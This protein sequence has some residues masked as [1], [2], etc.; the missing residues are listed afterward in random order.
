MNIFIAIFLYTLLC[1]ILFDINI[2]YSY[3]VTVNIDR[4]AT[5]SDRTYMITNKKTDELCPDGYS[6]YITERPDCF[7]VGAVRFRNESIKINESEIVLHYVYGIESYWKYNTPIMI[8]FIKYHGWYTR[9]YP[10]Y[11]L[12]KSGKWKQQNTYYYDKEITKG[13]LRLILDD[14]AAEVNEII[15]SDKNKEKED[16]GEVVT[17]EFKLFEGDKLRKKKSGFR[18]ND[19]SYLLFFLPVLYTFLSHI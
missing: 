15:E 11:V 3:Y 14:V 9:V 12:T 10:A 6:K 2:V 19:I 5:N 17:R 18:S 16:E 13:K 1:K 7:S 4:R 8:R